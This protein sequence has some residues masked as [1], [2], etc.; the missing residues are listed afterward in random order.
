[1]GAEDS[2]V[3]LKK[4]GDC[5]AMMVRLDAGITK[6]LNIS[7]KEEQDNAKRSATE[8]GVEVSI[9]TQ[10]YWIYCIYCI[11]QIVRSTFL[12]FFFF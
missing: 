8:K 9:S 2:V 12:V 6:A 3:A 5:L 11:M 1:L 4:R 7:T 10:K